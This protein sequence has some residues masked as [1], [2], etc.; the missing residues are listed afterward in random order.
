[1]V[2]AVSAGKP[3]KKCRLKHSWTN[4]FVVPVL[5]SGEYPWDTFR[6]ICAGLARDCTRCGR[7]QRSRRHRKG[8]GPFVVD[9]P[10]QPEPV[11][12]Q[13]VKQAEGAL[14]AVYRSRD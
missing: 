9:L 7:R 8:Y 13:Q 2:T 3:A 1:M 10:D 4:W 5:H 6:H 12:A 14:L 11:S